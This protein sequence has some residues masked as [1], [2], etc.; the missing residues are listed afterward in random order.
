MLIHR[1]VIIVET[2][3]NVRDFNRYG[4]EILKLSN[5]QVEVWD[6]SPFMRPLLYKQHNASDSEEFEE[7]NLFFSCGD[8]LKA[9]EGLGQDSAVISVINFDSSTKDIYKALSKQNIFYGLLSTNSIPPRYSKSNL[10]NTISNKFKQEI[11]FQRVLNA[12]FRRIPI[13]LFGVRPADFIIAGGSKSLGNAANKYPKLIRPSTPVVWA[14]TMDYDVY[15]QSG[16]KAPI[17]DDIAVFVDQYI[18]FHPD[19]RFRS[20]ILE[21]DTDHYYRVLSNFFSRIESEMGL[22]VI[23]APHPRADYAKLPDYFNGREIYQ[24]KTNQLVQRSRLVLLHY[25]TAVNFAVLY[26]KPVLFMT[27]TN[28]EKTYLSDYIHSMAKIFEKRPI[29][30]DSHQENNLGQELFIDQMVYDNYREVYIKRNGTPEKM[31]W[32]IVADYLLLQ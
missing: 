4:I 19:L 18:P 23:I 17:I 14:H 29:I 2:P 24:G 27:N 25:S 21:L 31:L 5:F 13:N 12:V 20:E 8:A 10:F 3:F 22:R 15:L 7:C 28:L 9:I 1:I 6:F 16:K 26:N 11:T 30:I 32:E